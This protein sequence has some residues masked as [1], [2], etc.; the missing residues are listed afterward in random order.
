MSILYSTIDSHTIQGGGKKGLIHLKVFT[1]KKYPSISG[2]SQVQV[3]IAQ[4]QPYVVFHIDARLFS[5][6]IEDIFIVGV[7]CL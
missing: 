7:R 3:C 6:Y 5:K 4:G 2:Y 1:I